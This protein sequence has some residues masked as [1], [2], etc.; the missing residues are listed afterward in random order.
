[1]FNE[2]LDRVKS[3]ARSPTSLHAD[4]TVQSAASPRAPARKKKHYLPPQVIKLNSEQGVLLLLGH[5][6]EGSE[7]A[8]DILKLLFPVR[9]DKAGDPVQDTFPG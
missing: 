3:M 5:A 6:W 8:R 2:F 9:R 7:Q 1:M 4:R